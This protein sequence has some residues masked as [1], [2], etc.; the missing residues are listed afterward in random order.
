MDVLD[1]FNIDRFSRNRCGLLACLYN[2]MKEAHLEEIG[3]RDDLREGSSVHHEVEQL[4]TH[5]QFQNQNNHLLLQSILFHV[6]Q[7]LPQW[8][9]W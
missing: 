4:T 8:E 1:H 2:C 9:G 3:P 7:I 6:S 5:S